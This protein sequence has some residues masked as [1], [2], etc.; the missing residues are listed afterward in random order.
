MASKSSGI[1]LLLE[2]TGLLKIKDK[3]T[4]LGI[5]ELS[6]MKFL[7]QEDWDSLGLS[8]IE[9]NKLK[10]HLNKEDD[11]KAAD[12]VADKSEPVS[13]LSLNEGIINYII[14]TTLVPKHG[15]VKLNLEETSLDGLVS[16]I[17]A[18]EQLIDGVTVELYSPQGYP[19]APEPFAY[20]KSLRYWQINNGTLVLAI[21][22]KHLM[23]A[24]VGQPGLDPTVGA[25]QIFVKH[26]KTSVIRVDTDKD[27]GKTLRQKISSKL[28]IPTPCIKLSYGG[29]LIRSSDAKLSTYN[30]QE[31]STIQM[32]TYGV[33]W[34]TSWRNNFTN[35]SC[36]PLFEQSE[37]SLTCFNSALYCVAMKLCKA[38]QDDIAK[39][40]GH[41]R[42]LVRCPPL[43]DSLNKLFRNEALLFSHK[44]AIQEILYLLFE[45]LLGSINSLA[46]DV[47]L[48]PKEV[49]MSSP[50]LFAYLIAEAK[51][52]DK[53]SENFKEFDLLC[54]LSNL[55]VED[56]VLIPGSNQPFDREAVLEKIQDQE[57]IPGCA[58][59]DISEADLHPDLVRKNLLLSFSADSAYIWQGKCTKEDLVDGY[60]VPV[61]VSSWSELVNKRK[62]LKYL[63]VLKPLELKINSSNPYVLTLN[64]SKCVV[65]YVERE[66]CA[67]TSRDYVLFNPQI[68]STESIDPDELARTLYGT[69]AKVQSFSSGQE[70]RIDLSTIQLQ[71]PVVTRRPEEAIIVLIDVSGSMNGGWDSGVTR[72]G[73]VKQLF[74]AFANRTMA[75]NLFHVIGLTVFATKVT[76]VSKV[77]E[78]FEQFKEYVDALHT[79]DTTAL[80]DAINDATT[81]LIEFT[82]KHSTILETG[83]IGE[84]PIANAPGGATGSTESEGLLTRL[85]KFGSSAPKHSPS[86]GAAK[87]LANVD[88]SPKL[89]AVRRRIICLTDGDDNASTKRPLDVINRCLKEN[90]IVDSFVIG[91]GNDNMKAISHAT[92]GCSFL[93]A[94]IAGAL[95]LFEMEGVLSMSR[96]DVAPAVGPLLEIDF[97]RFKCGDYDQE[98]ET[99]MPSEMAKKVISAKACLAKQAST[100]PTSNTGRA[101]KRIMAELAKIQKDPHASIEIYPSEDD[102]SFWRL[103]V[104]GPEFTPYENCVFLLYVKFLETY[105][106]SPPE[107]R[108]I[109]PIYH[110][111]INHSGR[112]CHSVFGRNYSSDLSMREILDCMYGLLLEPEPNDP[113]D[114]N[115][116]EQYFSERETYNEKA[117]RMA[118]QHAS[119]TVAQWRKELLGTVVTDSEIGQV[120]KEL[121]CS[122]CGDMF[123]DPVKTPFGDTYERM[124]IENHL[125]TVETDPKTGQPLKKDQLVPDLKMKDKIR[126]HQEANV[127]PKGWWDK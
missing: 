4:D 120:P 30:I 60:N 3:L 14:Y 91:N 119:K 6:D 96:R 73:A 70:E 71:D 87:P 17:T 103:L 59:D 48:D 39:V 32:W 74:H 76:C 9:L 24:E 88:T 113:L 85:F 23:M 101:S 26:N 22:R 57:P 52:T 95:K 124:A 68:G 50:T 58:I 51:I 55:R 27:T 118:R 21:P 25:C 69:V 72:L 105:P 36:L 98:P 125:D 75:Y 37:D 67:D 102:I 42:R 117:K 47:S 45:Q 64:S 86:K 66:A 109:T 111:N 99:Q 35:K 100:M 38:K 78:L 115:M 114:S 62:P 40:L 56:P 97:S 29:T 28:N 16:A 49:F 43:I 79:H 122:L 53:D 116:A 108:F 81:Q 5:E 110:C 106:M 89:P 80:Y 19:I 11:P 31:N 127:V 107:V 15:Q 126:L 20:E 65:V 90:V 82:T 93:P 77:T 61:V 13:K 10:F 94:E 1:L 8:K 84:C 54:C 83:G 12:S 112:I 123:T 34:S 33:A 46:S 7:Q 18:Q 92:G 63:E 41:I 2:E 104:T 44:V 121:I